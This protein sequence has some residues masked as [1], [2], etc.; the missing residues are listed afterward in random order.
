MGWTPDILD[1]LY[2]DN[3]DYHGLAWWADQIDKENEKLKNK[4]DASS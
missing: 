2:I 3:I 4:K 1:K